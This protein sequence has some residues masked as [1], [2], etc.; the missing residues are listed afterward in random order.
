MIHRSDFL[1]HKDVVFL[2]H[3]SFGACTHGVI[4]EQRRWQTKM[5]QQPVEF[6]RELEGYMFHARTQLANYVAASADDLVYVT[7]S[8]YGVNVLVHSLCNALAP[9]D[10]VV[11]NNHEYGACINTWKYFAELRG[12]EIITAEIPI[13]TSQQEV[14]EIIWAAVNNKTKVLFVSHITSPTAIE[15]PVQELVRRCKE[16]G[17][18]S[19]I[20]GSHAPGH[21]PLNLTELDADAYTANCHKWMCS[22]KGS[23]FLWVNKRIQHLVKPLTVSWG[24]KQSMPARPEFIGDQEFL[25]T[26]D[27]SAFLTVPFVIT[28]MAEND[29]PS[30]QHTAR[31]LRAQMVKKICTEFGLTTVHNNEADN[32]LQMGALIMPS[33]VDPESFQQALYNKHRVEVVVQR[34][35]QHVILRLSTHAHTAETDTMA[36]LQAIKKERQQ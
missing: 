28:W 21:I 13:P 30:V 26:R 23:A 2:N 17:I 36:L 7:N 9:G 10:N 8:T 11:I 15:F 14:L 32:R 19:I 29:W 16:H 35:E 24:W 20:D 34:W 18:I 4:N 31:E 5:E 22:P 12:V 27:C 6:F 25:G 33:D 3:G 1:L